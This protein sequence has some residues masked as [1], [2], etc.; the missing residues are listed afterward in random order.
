VTLLLLAS[1]LRADARRVGLYSVVSYAYRAGPKN[2]AIRM[3]AQV[4]VVEDLRSRALRGG[5]P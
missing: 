4:P 2:F 5:W 3:A 1:R